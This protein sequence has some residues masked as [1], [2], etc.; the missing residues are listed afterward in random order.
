MRNKFR[1]ELLLA[2]K[3]HTEIELLVS[4][5]GYG[6]FEDFKAKYPNSYL[7]LGIAEANI[8]GLASGMSSLGLIPIVYTIVPFLIFRPFE[9]IR[10]DLALHKRQVILVGVG[11]GLAYGSLG[12]THHSFEDIALAMSLPDM[13]I[14]SP[15]EP[16]DVSY[17]LA[18]SLAYKGP[19]YIRLGKNGEKKIPGKV[20]ELS[21]DAFH[22]YGKTDSKTLII[23]YGPICY[24]LVEYISA[25]NLNCRLIKI[26]KIKPLDISII[27]ICKNYAHVY[28]VEEHTVITG[29]GN[30]IAKKILEQN[31]K[32]KSFKH[33]GINDIFTE[34]VGDREFLLEHHK[35]TPE[36]ILENIK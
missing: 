11:G 19:T 35:L 24:D 13:Q 3:N 23:S 22:S 9:Q 25:K 27:N 21:S 14:F 34:L 31:I 32:L 1:D 29:L 20:E 16:D 15:A 5:I 26:L 36:Y 8:I 7:N 17:C 4:D 30:L 28:V 33:F 10:I 2:K 12:P 18:M 6:V